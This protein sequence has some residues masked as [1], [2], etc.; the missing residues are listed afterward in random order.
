MSA[1]GTVGSGGT[2]GTIIE[3][4]DDQTMTAS[5]GASATGTAAPAQEDQTMAASGLADAVG[6]TSVAQEG[7][8]M[9]AVGGTGFPVD[10]PDIR[11]RR[12]K[13]GSRVFPVRWPA[14]KN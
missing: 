5:G 6:T 4:Q 10:N 14:D 12:S 3:T 1:T 2:I 13:L 8:V 7:D 11:P 9:V